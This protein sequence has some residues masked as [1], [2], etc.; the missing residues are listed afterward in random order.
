MT[1]REVLKVFLE[2]GE[3]DDG[4]RELETSE[5]VSLDKEV[6]ISGEGFDTSLS[7]NTVLEVDEYDDIVVIKKSGK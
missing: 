4:L 2:I 1:L 3:L 7:V 5:T 6:V